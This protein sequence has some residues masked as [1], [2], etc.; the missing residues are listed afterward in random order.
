MGSLKLLKE[1]FN[2]STSATDIKMS[3]SV[4]LDTVASV[5]ALSLV[6]F[7]RISPHLNRRDVSKFIYL[8]LD[9]QLIGKIFVIDG[10]ST[11]TA[12]FMA[13]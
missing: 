2:S 12:L 3:K 8:N 4:S 5:Y 1:I 7:H 6:T 10:L 11:T 9:D 13:Y